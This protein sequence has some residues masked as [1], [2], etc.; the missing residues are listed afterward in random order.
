MLCYSEELFYIVFVCTALYRRTDTA[1]Y[2]HKHVARCECNYIAIHDTIECPLSRATNFVDLGDF[3]KI[4]F[5][6]N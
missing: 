4:C 5:T 1:V 2:I 3:H 6:E